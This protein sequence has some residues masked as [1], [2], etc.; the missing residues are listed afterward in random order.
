[1]GLF[2]KI[3]DLF[4]DEE[5]VYETKEIEVEENEEESKLPT[6]MRN[7]LEKEEQEKEIILENVKEQDEE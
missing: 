7:K 5:E 2:D 4:T 3:K 6:F 1:M